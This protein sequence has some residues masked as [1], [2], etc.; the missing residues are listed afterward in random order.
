MPRKKVNIIDNS[1]ETVKVAENEILDAKPQNLNIQNKS[2]KKSNK[3]LVRNSKKIVDSN[4][5]SSLIA[6]EV[7]NTENSDI[8]ISDNIETSQIQI[9]DLFQ[10]STKKKSKKKAISVEN[11]ELIEAQPEIKSEEISDKIEIIELEKVEI[12]DLSQKSSKKKNKKKAKTEIIVELEKPIEIIEIVD[13]SA[14]NNEISIVDNIKNVPETEIAKEQIESAPEIAIEDNKSLNTNISSKTLK[15]KRAKNKKKVETQQTTEII[16]E[17]V[18]AEVIDVI[19]NVVDSKQDNE[20]LT[21]EK[22]DEPISSEATEPITQKKSKRKNKK[23]KLKVTATVVEPEKEIEQSLIIEEPVVES[24][25]EIRI[26]TEKIDVE[27][28]ENKDKAALIAERKRA[29]RIRRKERKN[30]KLQNELK[31]EIINE[32]VL[33]IIPKIEPTNIEVI[34]NPE[35]VEPESDNDK[36]IVVDLNKGLYQQIDLSKA[37]P[38]IEKIEESTP[39][40][41]PKIDQVIIEEQIPVLIT[42]E[43][44]PEKLIPSKSSNKNNKKNKNKNKDLKENKETSVEPIVESTTPQQVVVLAKID[45][46]LKDKNPEVPEIIV[47]VPAK[48]VSKLEKEIIPVHISDNKEIKAVKIQDKKEQKHNQLIKVN[49]KKQL[50]KRKTSLKRLIPEYSI[51]PQNKLLSNADKSNSLIMN[52]ISK[53]DEFMRKELYI[54]SGMKFI[55]AVSGG[56]DSIVLL[57]IM[58]QLASKY[59]FTIYVGHFNHNLRGDNSKK[60]E[61][62]VKSLA[63]Q[64]KLNYYHSSGNVKQFSEKN[65]I[66]IEHSAR[67]LRYNFYERTART[68]SAD[69]VASAHNADDSAETFLIN[70]MRGSG[71]TGLSGIPAKRHLVKNVLIV[72]PLIN[73]KKSEIIEYAKMRNL[74][75]REDESN[76]LMNYTRNKVRLDLLPKLKNDYNPSIVDTLNRTARL[77]QSADSIVNDIVKKNIVNLVSDISTERFMIKISIL[78][79]FDDFIQGELIQSAMQKYFR[80]HPLNLNTIDRIL[81]L[82]NSITGSVA[83]INNNYLVLRDRDYLIFSKKSNEVDINLKI[84]KTGEFK[85]GKFKLI[86]KEVKKSDVKFNADPRIEYLDGDLLPNNLEIRNWI[87]GDSFQPLGMGTQ[88][89]SDFLTNIKMPLI[90]KPKVLV[91]KNKTDIIWLIGLRLSEKFKVTAE[92]KSFISA[93]IKVLN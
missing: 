15:K 13:N 61:Q 45:D 56:V 23:N 77:I 93:E 69:F 9:I 8:I 11:I 25:T 20:I 31:E 86:L 34:E 80:S 29:K 76:S 63:E 85:I 21:I 58:A 51:I 53:V 10:K 50:E 48:F 14:L 16:E 7:N 1:Q 59:Y 12:I 26:E 90:D 42:Q 44:E 19:E 52:A 43:S 92:T 49:E 73:F 40:I 27:T 70:L 47:E 5:E 28:V 2:N 67:T 17:K 46:E 55:L 75:W 79:T 84:A 38:I 88:K 24:E 33:E 22:V 36:F 41:E 18:P 81:S 83:E 65:S 4:D 87:Q 82:L 74:K 68:I 32:S 66:S 3:K 72:R 57:D 71:L 91:L 35:F 62:F 6:E 37:E 60:D 30:Q 54:E 64:Y 89:V 78:Q 39:S